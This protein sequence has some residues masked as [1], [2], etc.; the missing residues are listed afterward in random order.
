MGKSDPDAGPSEASQAVN[1]Q[2]G[3][4]A[5]EQESGEDG[6]YE[7]EEDN[8][9]HEDDDDGDYYGEGEGGGNGGDSS[10]MEGGEEG[11]GDK[12]KTPEEGITKKGKEYIC[13]DCGYKSKHKHCTYQ[14][15]REHHTLQ[16]KATCDFCQKEFKN[17]RYRNSHLN[18][19]HGITQRMLKGEAI[20]Q[21]PK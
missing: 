4:S 10:L 13:K 19:A 21:N 5:D 3:A 15:Y 7:E 6:D 18:H 2:G 20:V 16:S 17:T 14:H 9:D 11:A 8:S 1:M 12:E